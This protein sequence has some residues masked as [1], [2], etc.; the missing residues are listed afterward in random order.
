M[1]KITSFL[2]PSILAIFLVCGY[3]Q[4]SPIISFDNQ[5]NDANYSYELGDLISI[6]IWISNLDTVDL[7]GFDLGLAFNGLVTSYQDLQFNSDMVEFDFLDASNS[8]DTISLSGV[9]FAFD[10]SGQLDAFKIATI[11]FSA[12]MVGISEISFTDILL[13]DTFGSSLDFDSF[14]ATITVEQLSVGIAEPNILALGVLALLL[15]CVSW[16]RRH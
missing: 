8:L 4:A 1:K 16:R 10:L 2:L 9:S 15:G 11:D 13:S 14:I 7:G 5:A 6:D 12:D 3:S